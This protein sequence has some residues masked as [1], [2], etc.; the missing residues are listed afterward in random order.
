MKTAKQ[1]KLGKPL[2]RMMW[3]AWS[4]QIETDCKAW[5]SASGGGKTPEAVTAYCAGVRDGCRQAARILEEHG[6]LILRE[7]PT[8]KI[9]GERGQFDAN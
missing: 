7:K 3:I 9:Q 4:E 8:E 1:E 6:H 5:T 2:D